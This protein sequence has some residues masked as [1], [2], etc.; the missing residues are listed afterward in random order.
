M[1]APECREKLLKVRTD[2]MLTIKGKR[3]KVRAIMFE[4][5]VSNGYPV[6]AK[7]YD[8]ILKEIDAQE[9][10]EIMRILKG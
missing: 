2:K 3:D 9:Q 5:L 4:L 10:D 6:V 1:N 8:D 7:L